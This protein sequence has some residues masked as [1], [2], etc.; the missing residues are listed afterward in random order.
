MNPLKQTLLSFMEHKRQFL[1]SLIGF[2]FLF[3]PILSSAQYTKLLD[4]GSTSKGTN[5]YSAPISD[6]TFLYG[7]TTS[8]G[9]NNLGTIYKIKTDGTGFSKLLD[10]DG[11]NGSNPYGSLYSDG[12]FLY[13]TTYSGG[14]NSQ[15]T[16]FKLKTDGS[17]YTKL[18]DFAYATTGG[19]P[20]GSLIS[21]GTFLYGTTSQG[22]SKTYGTVFKIKTD[23]S[24]FLK[25][26]EF[27]GTTN[28]GLPYGSLYSDGTFLY[29]TTSGQ[30][31]S[32]GT[33][34]KVQTD[35]TNASTIY[36]FTGSNTHPFG[37]LVSDGT[38]LYGMTNGISSG[39]SE[40]GTM[41]KIMPDGTNFSVIV[42]FNNNSPGAT[43]KG[44]L[45]YDG[46]YLYGTTTDYG[47][48]S[49]GTIFK[50][51]TDGSGLTKLLDNNIGTNGSA[52][53]GTLLLSGGVLYGV[54]SGF[55][56][57]VAPFLPGT[58]F[59]IN[60]D[61]SNYT[62][63]FFFDTEGNSPNGSLYSDGTF[64]YGM[65]NQGGIYNYG[66]IF[67]VKTDGTSFQRLYDFDL[68]NGRLPFGSLVSDGT[69]LYGMTNQGG[70]NDGGVVF[71][72]KKDGTNFSKLL[73]FDITNTGGYPRASL[74]SDGTFLYG[75]TNNGGV[76]SAGT[77]FKIKP[78]G[79]SYAK[80]LDFDNA[81]TGGYPYG[82]LL[83][84]GVFLYGT[85]TSGGANGNGTIFKIKPDGSSF[86]NILD[87][88]YTSSGN[89]PAGDLAYDG[90]F[91]FALSSGGG[92]NDSG[93]II[94]IKPDGT[95]FAKLFD[96]NDYTGSTP[97]GSL[98]LNGAYFYG[99]CQNGGSNGL[100]TTFRI[101][102]DGTGFQKM[103]DLAD[104][105]HPQGSLIS[106]GTF[107]YGMT[108]GGGINGLGTLF[109]TTLTPF[110]SISN[111]S[112]QDAVEGTYITINGI[113]F[114]PTFA[115]N[116][117]TFN[118]TS[119]VVVSGT[120][121]TLVA[122]VPVGATTGPIS[123]TSGST[124]TSAFD[125]I[126]D[127]DAV[128]V[129][130]TVQNCNVNFLPPTYD[131]I[132]SRNYMATET[133]I[134]VNPTDKV[135]ISFSSINM[136]GD[137]LYVYDGPTS[138]S[139]LLATLDNTNSP[140][141]II[142]TGVGGELTFVYQWGDGTT[143]WQ[144]TITCVSASGAPVITTQS[145]ATQIGGKITLDLKPLIT[146]PSLDL[147]SL[148][149]VTPPSSGA[150]A[151][152][153]ANGI[154]TIDYNGKLFAG[155]EQVTIQACDANGQCSQ[156][157]FNIEVVGDIVVYN[158]VSPNGANPKLVIQYIDVL[159]DT[160]ANNVYIF[161]RWENLVWH[162][163]NYNNDSVVFTGSSDGG[164]SLPS[165]VYFYKIDFVSGRKSKTGFIAL[166]RQ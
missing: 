106:D 66:T 73:D 102:P 29:G 98:I 51:K 128:M 85:T 18:F 59:K 121:S 23:G 20:Y 126:I 80:L 114:N 47:A 108:A 38:F 13:G 70:T 15:G 61:G 71:K 76:N 40:Y 74:Y 96:F 32:F 28:G 129:D 136:Q 27:D 90:T 91:L 39:F 153:D 99:M 124:G 52:P 1:F 42:N 133:F 37:G 81:T 130:V 79:S 25:L 100:G 36:Q 127:T 55:G 68:T 150:T 157:T 143:D 34:F 64:L 9:A 94:K 2:C 111:F 161:D 35:G 146:T 119:A 132:R 4:F 3:L 139:P 78:D 56:A 16:I 41:F 154:L 141:D 156:Q 107:L 123:V 57:G 6:G 54:K 48:N 151:S 50:V 105:S 49:R 53:E 43:P 84:D 152:I 159:P 24:G 115:N 137:A 134:P 69:F 117:V 120:D 67:K 12:T 11:N 19:F 10:F 62:K 160:K 46:T 60:T 122:I 165:G 138:S 131:Y 135:K 164:S 72:I 77:I 89:Y 158:G 58:I 103:L 31:L 82:S 21:D 17:G 140:V 44:S 145:L 22:G 110:I 118:G 113:G 95:G 65:T 144:A 87:L 33:I 92:S 155:T 163:N 75:M 104:G 166:R 142:A 112:P 88:E 14:T 7:M 8:G 5:P 101:K 148:Q 149:V 162:G 63:L 86:T 83:S 45:T 97:Y 116:V 147:A 26:L 93:T 30:Y 109:K 125:F